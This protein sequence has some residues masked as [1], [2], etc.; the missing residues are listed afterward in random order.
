[1][2]ALGKILRFESRP[3]VCGRD[4]WRLA[5]GKTNQGEIIGRVY[6]VRAVPPSFLEYY[7][8]GLKNYSRTETP[9]LGHPDSCNWN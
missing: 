8:G 6:Y 7:L 3:A 5:T 4:I 1:M 2:T 9:L